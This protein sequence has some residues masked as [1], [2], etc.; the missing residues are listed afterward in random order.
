MLSGPTSP[1]GARVAGNDEGEEPEEFDEAL[2]NWAAEAMRAPGWTELQERLGRISKAAAT[3]ESTRKWSELTRAV[4]AGQ[5]STRRWSEVFRAVSQATDPEST[6]RWN[7][8]FRAASEATRPWMAEMDRSRAQ[9][10]AMTRVAS[11]ALAAQVSISA[12]GKVYEITVTDDAGL[13]DSLIV[14]VTRETA[15]SE[16]TT[17]PAPIISVRNGALFAAIYQF[18]AAVLAQ[19]PSEAVRSASAALAILLAILLMEELKREDPPDK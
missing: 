12:T 15:T 5:E 11:A 6:R 4:A 17:P 14:E 8:V 2:Q 13:T 19:H 16:P 7:E 18:V 1:N 10:E 3:P 9:F